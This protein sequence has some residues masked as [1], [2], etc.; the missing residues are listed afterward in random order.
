MEKISHYCQKC[1]AA[2]KP[3]ELSCRECGTRLMIVT[4]PPSLRH[5]EELIPSFYED[6]LLERVSLLEFRLAQISE[7]LGMAYEFIYKQK[8][9]FEKDQILIKSFVET[10]TK[11]DPEIAG[12][13]AGKFVQVYEEKTSF[14]EVENRRKQLLEKIYSAHDNRNNELFSHLVEEGIK[15]LNDN[16]E[17]QGFR[18]LERAA[19]LSPQNIPLFLFIAEKLFDQDKFD[20]AKKYLKKIYEL[21][22][23]ETQALLLLGVIYADE[24]QAEKARKFLSVLAGIPDTMICANY[25]WGILAAFEGNWN[26]ALAAFKEC[27]E[28]CEEAEIYYLIGSCYFQIFDYEKSLHFFEKALAND[29]NFADAWFMKGIIFAVLN[30]QKESMQ[31][32]NSAFEIKEAGA[33]CLQFYKEND[34]TN[35]KTA[36]PFLHFKNDNKRV[37]TNASVR[38][39]KF[40]RRMVSESL[41]N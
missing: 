9:I 18:T 22:P 5:E 31:A 37:L 38:L 6:H 8:E 17:K 10:L 12:N 3:G 4:V 30:K 15:L 27:S 39:N 32:R 26:E 21:S 36:L 29:K 35:M 25:V 33:K 34:F 23:Q 2:N 7:Q 20:S 14:A 1:R 19:L 40:L 11:I 13:L 16:E 28:V 41:K 24:A